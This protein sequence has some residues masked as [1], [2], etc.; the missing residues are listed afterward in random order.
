MANREKLQPQRKIRK[1][2]Y[3][4]KERKERAG[5]GMELLARLGLG[6][7]VLTPDSSIRWLGVWQGPAAPT[8]PTE[9]CILFHCPKRRDALNIPGH[10]HTQLGFFGLFTHELSGAN[11]HT[12]AM[13]S[14]AS[15]EKAAGSPSRVD[16][17]DLH[18]A[19]A[20]LEISRSISSRKLGESVKCCAFFASLR[21]N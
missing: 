12:V 17:S 20:H 8:S 14:Q 21:A 3:S 5:S 15:L 2:G 19:A 1:K 11:V 16:S 7:A 9:L 6:T 13:A 10:A 4:L 18:G